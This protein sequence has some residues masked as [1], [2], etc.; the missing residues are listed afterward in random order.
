MRRHR[1]P[2]ECGAV[3]LVA[4]LAIAVSA[5]GSG[6]AKTS[7][8]SSQH[9]ISNALQRSA[10]QSS[11]SPELGFEVGYSDSAG[12]T[13]VASVAMGSPESLKGAGV[14]T[15]LGECGINLGTALA[16]PMTI[17]IDLT[18]KRDLSGVAVSLTGIS[19]DSGYALVDSLGNPICPPDSP[20]QTLFEPLT[21]GQPI[22]L[23]LTAIIPGALDSGSSDG[24]ADGS[25]LTYTDHGQAPFPF[26]NLGEGGST[27][28]SAPWGPRAFKCSTSDSVYVSFAIKAPV[29]AKT[30]NG[31]LA[32]V[33]SSQRPFFDADV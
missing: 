2:F 21:P 31:S 32:A 15:D 6:V 25:Y 29:R 22:D 5:C 23:S 7:T 1:G 13:A 11:I 14:S 10:P 16:E 19:S 18:S 33:T 30:C 17:D 4:T 9:L 12:D 20:G 3:A 26:V 28:M 24:A 8:S 27:L